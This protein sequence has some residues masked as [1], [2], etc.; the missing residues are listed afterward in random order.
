MPHWPPFSHS[1][2]L[3]D[4]D[5]EVIEQVALVKTIC[6]LKEK[7]GDSSMRYVLVKVLASDLLSISPF[8]SFAG[9]PVFVA[10]S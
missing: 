2:W 6:D 4:G 8:C 3:A 10:K 5:A 1:Q 9:L 7:E